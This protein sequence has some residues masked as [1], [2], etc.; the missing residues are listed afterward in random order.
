MFSAFS[1]LSNLD[2]LEKVVKFPNICFMNNFPKG[3][4]CGGRCLDEKI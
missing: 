3:D 4:N 1:V 2:E